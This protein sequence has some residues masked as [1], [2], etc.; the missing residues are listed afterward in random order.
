MSNISEH[1]TL[2][3]AIK[4]Q[5]AI[6]KGIDNTPNSDQIAAMKLVAEKV[7]EPIRNHFG[8]PIGVSSFF[9][10]QKLNKAIGGAASSQHTK[11]EAIDIDGD[12]FGGV[13][14]R[15][16]FDFV[17]LNLEWDQLIWEYGDSYNPSW[18]HVSYKAIGN[19]RQILYVGLP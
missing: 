5:T 11:G 14:N 15:A 6:R 9:R 4:S 2:A 1:I 8:V 13:S 17:R 3:E 10:S 7:F 18:V 19:R 12:I 16:I